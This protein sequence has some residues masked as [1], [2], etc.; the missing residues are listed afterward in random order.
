MT[1]EH[2]LGEFAAAWKAGERPRVEDYAERVAPAE[3]ERF[4]ALAAAWMDV[5]PVP[6]WEPATAARIAAEPD[7]A[8]V[9]EAVRSERALWPELLPALRRRRG[10]S[11]DA[12]AGALVERLELRGG[13]RRAAHWLGRMERGELEPA[14][15][16]RRLLDALGGAL[17]VATRALEE[18]GDAGAWRRPAAAAGA[19]LLWRAEQPSQADVGRHLDVLADVASAPGGEGGG[20]EA[21][22]DRLF[23]GGRD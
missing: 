9:V 22:L 14:G 21:A 20:P 6:D 5:A 18:A 11:L 12:L 19:G 1:S 10:L 23:T 3:R 17:G 7:V 13:E 2:A 8:L 4:L 15:V 16:S